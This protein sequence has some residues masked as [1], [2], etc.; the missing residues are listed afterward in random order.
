MDRF[1]PRLVGST[2]RGLRALRHGPL[3][4]RFR[5]DL[6]LPLGVLVA[7]LAGAA[8]LA[9]HHRLAHPLGVVDWVLLVVGPVA[10]TLRRTY[11]VAVLWVTFAAT[12][13]LAGSRPA[14]LSLIV[15]FFVAA[16]G[17]HRR[18]AWIVIAAGFIASVWLAPLA[19]GRSPASLEVA[20]LLLGWLT[21]LVIAAEATRIARERTAQKAVASSLD[22]RRR[23]SEERLRMARELHDVIG[24][25]IS[26]INLQASVGLEL[27]E[28]RPDQARDALSAIK[29]VSKEALSELR[30]LLESLRQADDDAPRSPTPGL[31]R[32]AE[33][34]EGTRSWG[35]PVTTD[36]QG[37]K[38]P[39]PAAVDLAAYRIIQESL[40]N[41]TRHAGLARVTIRLCYAPDSLQV[42]IL[43]DGRPSATRET[44]SGSGTGIAGMRERALALGGRLE[45][46]RR[47]GAGFA[48][49][50]ELP[51]REPA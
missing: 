25:N 19:Y 26:L 42:E 45:A 20:L 51:I 10:L 6:A 16:T 18:A 27:I 13:S 30:S 15:A 9:A 11:P 7:Q 41:V 36:V 43:D 37:K 44:S 39:L 33:L 2:G 48:V 3:E 14:Y 40:T 32:L 50:A 29:T 1:A 23:A 38:R 46:G 8:L 21:V 12:L 35:L 4:L 28:I 34:I 17:G 31:G 47:T 22:A 5:R 49:T 24:H